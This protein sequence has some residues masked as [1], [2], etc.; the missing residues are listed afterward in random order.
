[1]GQLV[2]FSALDDSG[3]NIG[4]FRNQTTVNAT[5]NATAQFF[6]RST[7]YSGIANLSV[8][9]PGSTSVGTAVIDIISPTP[10]S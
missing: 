1:M 6:P 4:S 2:V 9:I 5:G 7:E 10:T 3:A 8:E